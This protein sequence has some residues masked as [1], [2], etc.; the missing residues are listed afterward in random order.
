MTGTL[1]K[2]DIMDNI[3][4]PS[5]HLP[6]QVVKAQLQ[7]NSQHLPRDESPIKTLNMCIEIAGGQGDNQKQCGVRWDGGSMDGGWKHGNIAV[8]QSDNLLSE[9]SRSLTGVGAN[10]H[11][12]SHSDRNKTM[13]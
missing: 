4:P 12:P 9:S 5:I 13:K 11:L 8:K 1:H 7:Y 10:H 2:L 6:F 3:L